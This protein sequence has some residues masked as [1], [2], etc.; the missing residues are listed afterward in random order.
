MSKKMKEVVGSSDHYYP[1]YFWFQNLILDQT[2]PQQIHDRGELA[3][4]CMSEITKNLATLNTNRKLPLPSA[5]ASY[6]QDG[7][8]CMIT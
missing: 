3:Q 7:S 6:L 1:T 4:I 8:Q 5:S 2:L